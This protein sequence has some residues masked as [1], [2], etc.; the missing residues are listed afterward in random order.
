MGD[1]S[2]ARANI[3]DTRYTIY[4]MIPRKR[5]QRRGRPYNA[6]SY[7]ERNSAGRFLCRLKHLRAVATRCD[8][9]VTT[10]QA[11]VLLASVVLY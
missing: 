5:N 4:P 9:W 11:T 1:M 8:K 7:R 2:A 3:S 6:A 10:Y